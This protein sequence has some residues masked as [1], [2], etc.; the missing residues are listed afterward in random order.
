MVGLG[1][2]GRGEKERFREFLVFGF[3]DL[4]VDRYR[5]VD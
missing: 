5:V 1:L 3:G 4:G 2:V